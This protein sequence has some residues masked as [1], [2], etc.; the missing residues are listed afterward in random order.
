MEDDL[1]D[2]K[3][4]AN[5]ISASAHTEITSSRSNNTS[6]NTSRVAWNISSF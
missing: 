5:D 3:L 1:I 2:D 6:N 4:N